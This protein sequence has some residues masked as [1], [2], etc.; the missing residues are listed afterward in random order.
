M[1]TTPTLAWWQQPRWLLTSLG[2]AV[3]IILALSIAVI[4]LAVGDDSEQPPSAATPTTS[5]RVAAAPTASPPALSKLG[6]PITLQVNGVPALT[7]AV[8]SIELDA[9]CPQT[10]IPPR[11]G[12]MVLVGLNVKTTAEFNGAS[13]GGFCPPIRTTAGRSS[14]PTASPRPD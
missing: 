13:A 4:V 12:H 11:D 14:D 10:T 3:A 6:E 7:Y 5:P 9:P 2:V 1:S 8:T